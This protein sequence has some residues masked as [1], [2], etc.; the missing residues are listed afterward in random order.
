MLP[1]TLALLFFSKILFI[2]SWEIQKDRGRDIAE[3][4]VGSMQGALCGTQSWNQA[5]SWRQ[6]LNRWATQ[7]SQ[8]LALLICFWLVGCLITWS[9]SAII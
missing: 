4:E 5:L 3:G 2:H 9:F 7:E 6:M 8:T 1:Q